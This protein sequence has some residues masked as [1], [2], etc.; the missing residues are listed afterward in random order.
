MPDSNGSSE[1]RSTEEHS[2]ERTRR[3]PE[4]TTNLR[5]SFLAGIASTASFVAVGSAIAD[6]DEEYAAP[7][8]AEPGNNEGL[9]VEAHGTLEGE[10]RRV[11]DEAFVHER[12]FRSEDL[13]EHFGDPVFEWEPV[14]IAAEWLSPRIVRNGGMTYET[15][16]TQVVG[17]EAEHVQAEQTIKAQ[18][19]GSHPLVTDSGAETHAPDSIEEIPLYNYA[20]ES[21]ARRDPMTRT[22]PTN[23]AFEEGDSSEIGKWMEKVCDW[24]SGVDD[25]FDIIGDLP[26]IGGGND[27]PYAQSRYLNYDG[28]II[29]TDRHVMKRAD[30]RVFSQLHIR[31]YDV[32]DQNGRFDVVGQA[33]RD[34]EDHNKI[35]DEVPIDE[36]DWKYNRARDQAMSCWESNDKATENAGGAYTNHYDA[37]RDNVDTHDGNIGGIFNDGFEIPC[38]GLFCGFDTQAE[39]D[40][41]NRTVQHED[42]GHTEQGFTLGPHRPCPCMMGF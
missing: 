36:I 37:G 25:F 30:W 22:A 34:P 20:S 15:E 35:R 26:G 6:D 9:P 5:R 32:S 17:T 19:G 4:R 16:Q 29:E 27:N 33:H 41:A 21:R 12:T 2:S 28:T 39:G 18:N 38:T 8:A 1:D 11:T 3:Q 31:L 10:I 40:S 13:D 42:A 24:T 23:L 14:A 7:A